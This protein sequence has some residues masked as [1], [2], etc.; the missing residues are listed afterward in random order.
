[1]AWPVAPRKLDIA[2]GLGEEQ[3]MEEL[4]PQTIYR[5]QVLRWLVVL[6]SA[7]ALALTVSLAAR[8]SATDPLVAL[9]NLP[10]ALGLGW[11]AWAMASAKASSLTFDGETLTDNAGVAVCHIDEVDRIERGFAMFKP[12][13]GFAILLKAEKPRGWSPGL[14][15]R[16]GK[17]IG[18]GGATYGRA[19]RNMADS[20]SIALA[21]RDQP[22]APAKKGAAK[23]RRKPTRKD[24]ASDA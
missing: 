10:A 1:M 13:G 7:V 23:T 22:A 9:I 4:R 2:A 11:F 24:R 14:W 15:W 6:A 18:V 12:S 20:M 3:G 17:R 16:W 8:A 19:A 21:M 5:P